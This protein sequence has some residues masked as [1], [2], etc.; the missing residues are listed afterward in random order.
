M[1]EQNET[2]NDDETH[3]EVQYQFAVNEPLWTEWKDTVPRSKALRDRIAELL[4]Q[5]LEARQ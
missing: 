3:N 1:G 2:E 5:D 4:E